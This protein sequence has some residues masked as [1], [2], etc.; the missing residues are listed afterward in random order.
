MELVLKKQIYTA[1]KN[2]Y[3]ELR[4][5][6][7]L[8]QV[9][10]INY[11]E[12]LYP[13]IKDMKYSISSLYAK[14]L[15]VLDQSEKNELKKLAREGEKKYKDFLLNNNIPLD[16]DKIHY[17]C[18]ICEDQGYVNGDICICFRNEMKKLIAKFNLSKIPEDKCFSNF[19]DKPSNDEEQN[20]KL[21]EI[22]DTFLDYCKNYDSYDE[23]GFFFSGQPGTGKSFM[24]QCVA[25]E[26]LEAGVIVEYI[27]AMDFAYINL[28]F[29]RSRRFRPD[30]E[31]LDIIENRYAL[32]FEVEFLI[33][34]DLGI[35]LDLYP[36]S[37]TKLTYLLSHR[38]DAKK[39]TLLISNM[40][41]KAV[42]ENYGERVSS[43]LYGE[44]VPINFIGTDIR[45]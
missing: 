19:K 39:K 9:Q 37:G 23:L 8:R 3:A 42:I 4:R 45:A 38:A 26:L 40:D 12:S 18:P 25:H 17:S 28:E 27:S 29:D 36:E 32:L 43:R 6:A 16:Y 10:R 2:H 33:I 21:N 31:S 14:Q 13:Q 1:I 34:D 5:I 44:L 35:E 24:A 7:K 22:K 15:I 11:Y 41:S 30:P 20:K